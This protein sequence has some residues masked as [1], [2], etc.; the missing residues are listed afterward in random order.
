MFRDVFAIDE[1][2]AALSGLR[3][4][5][6]AVK[7]PVGESGLGGRCRERVPDYETMLP[8]VCEALELPKR[9]ALLL[10][11]A[12]SSPE[13]PSLSQVSFAARHLLYAALRRVLVL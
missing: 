12:P 3:S 1:A 4:R 10:Q 9:I 8:K 2:A 11:Q 7:P 5:R 13:T 6:A